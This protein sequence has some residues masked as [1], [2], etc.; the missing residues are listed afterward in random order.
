MQKIIRFGC[1]LFVVGA[2]KK[3]KEKQKIIN[4]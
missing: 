2:S 1:N 4:P 3:R